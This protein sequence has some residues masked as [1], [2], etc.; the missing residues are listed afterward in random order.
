MNRSE[1]TNY[2]NVSSTSEYINPGYD[3]TLIDTS[4][5]N[6]SVLEMLQDLAKGHSIFYID[7]DDSY[8]YF[9]VNCSDIFFLLSAKKNLIILYNL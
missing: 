1:F 9:K 2:F 4:E 5:Y 8:F 7:P 6:G 3:A